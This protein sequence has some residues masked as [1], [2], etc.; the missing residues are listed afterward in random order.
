MDAGFVRGRRDG[1]EKHV[2]AVLPKSLV[3]ILRGGLLRRRGMSV[4]RGNQPLGSLFAPG[5]QVGLAMAR[6]SSGSAA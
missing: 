5:G 1:F 3:E 4:H 6:T 2:G